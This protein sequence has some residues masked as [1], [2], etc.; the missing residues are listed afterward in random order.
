MK[1]RGGRLL[2][3]MVVVCVVGAGPADAAMLKASMRV[4]VT[5]VAACRIVPGQAQGCAP[6]VRA[7]QASIP[8]P[9]PLVTYNRDPRT[10]VTVESVEF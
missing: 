1:K 2:A 9:Q 8:A 7:G 5:V 6:T 3:A 4:S 10:G